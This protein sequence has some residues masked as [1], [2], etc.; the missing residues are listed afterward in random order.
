VVAVDEEGGRVSRLE[1]LLAELP[2]FATFGATGDD[3]A[4]RAR[5][6]QPGADLAALG[7]TMDFAPVADV[8][9]GA[10]DPTIGDRSASAEPSVVART[11]RA[12]ACGLLDGGTLPVIKHFPG[13]GSV[14]TDSHEGLPVQPATSDQLAARDLVP[15]RAAVEAGLPIVMVGHLDLAALDPGVPS[16]LSPATY[17]LLREEL[18][19]DGV[20]ITDAL[21]MGA[22]PPAAPGD[23]AVRAL[24]AGADLVL[25]PRDVAAAHGAIVAAVG[26]GRL[27]LER[28]QEAATRVVALQMWSAGPV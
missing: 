2:P 14:T 20:T 6:A 1:G 11:V 9:I 25:M 13:H 17:R 3:A 8:T 19:F 15:F 23:E 21:D 5:F 16:S 18:G 4:T 24:A 22:V 26:D 7:L 10:A 27:P 28:L 12:A